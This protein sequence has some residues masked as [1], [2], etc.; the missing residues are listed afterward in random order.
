VDGLEAAKAVSLDEPIGWAEQL[1]FREAIPARGQTFLER[2]SRQHRQRLRIEPGEVDAVRLRNV[3]LGQDSRPGLICPDTTSAPVLGDHCS[4]GL[5]GL[6]YSRFPLPEPAA[7]EANAAFG[8]QAGEQLR[9][10]PFRRPPDRENACNRVSAIGDLYGVA[11]A[12][13][14]QVLPQAVP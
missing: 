1:A 10:F 14:A 2:R 3:Q 9:L 13:E 7:S 12:D 8:D 4:D 6:Q 11:I 5:A